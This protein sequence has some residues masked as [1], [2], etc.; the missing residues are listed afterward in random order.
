MEPGDPQEQRHS[1][2]APNTPPVQSQRDSEADR[3]RRVHALSELA[4][5]ASTHATAADSSSPAPISRQTRER[6]TRA[7]SLR[8]RTPWFVGEV[9]VLTLASTAVLIVPHLLSPATRP[10]RKP[11]AS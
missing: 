11:D 9:L 8:H 7:G 3:E 5:Q 1:G 4:H 2:E 6:R 10:V